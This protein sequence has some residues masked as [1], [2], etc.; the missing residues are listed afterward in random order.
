NVL[1]TTQ[2]ALAFVLVIGC[3]LMVRSFDA[4]RSVDPG[5]STDNVLT[6]SVRPPLTRYEGSQAVA[7]FYDR[8]IE[9]L[10]AVPGVERVGAVDALP[11]TGRGRSLG[12]VIEEFPP[13]TGQ[14]PPVFQ[15]RRTAPG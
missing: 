6:F 15:V 4:L 11:L 9:R 10:A 2:V 3:G 13:L 7:Q 5:F 1:V 8:L 12:I 14:F